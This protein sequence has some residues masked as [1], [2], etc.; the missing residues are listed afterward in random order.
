MSSFDLQNGVAVVTGAASGI[1]RATALAL[2]AK[3]C[4]LALVD[5]D[6]DGLAET[7]EQ[8]GLSGVRV[9]THTMDVAD[10]DAVAAFPEQVLAEHDRVTVLVNNAGVSLV[11]RFEEL[12]LEEFRWLFEVNFFA[13][14]GFT[15][16]FLPHLQQARAAHIANVSSLFGLVAPAE[17]TAYSASKFAVRGFS[18]ALRHELD[19]T[20]VGVTVVH[21][22]GVRTGIA[23]NARLAAGAD[24][25]EAARKGEVF[26]KMF[27]KTP[28][29]E[30]GA[31]IVR[32]IERRQPR[33]VVAEGARQGDLLQRLL[34]AGY[35]RLMR[36]N[37]ARLAS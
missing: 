13:V 28:P 31:A 5:R 7:A 9:T 17:Q 11:G 2:A 30:V 37:F 24:A 22:G 16:A 20:S 29:E 14:V 8:A 3:G 34:P 21:P 18:E 35:W 32:A 27:L 10:A 15:K 1:G 33:L 26:D 6:A 19:G 12:T 23:R 36:R 4:H 25:E